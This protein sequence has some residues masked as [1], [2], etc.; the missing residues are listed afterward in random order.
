MHCE[1]RTKSLHFL[2]DSIH[3]CIA[4]FLGS[5]T[6]EKIEIVTNQSA[7]YSTLRFIQQGQFNEYIDG[8]FRKWKIKHANPV[9]T[10][11]VV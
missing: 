2:M 5:P 11:V 8:C 6:I 7:P 10:V 9:A 3:D 1:H 4:W